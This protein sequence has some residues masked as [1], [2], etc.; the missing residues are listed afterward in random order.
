MPNKRLAIMFIDKYSDIHNP[1][2][3]EVNK[4]DYKHLYINHKISNKEL[5]KA[6]KLIYSYSVQN[7]IKNLICDLG[8]LDEELTPTKEMTIDEIEKILG[9]K[10]KIVQK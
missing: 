1:I 4:N 7:E 3:C 2:L 9:Y 5:N 10:I 6:I 8:L